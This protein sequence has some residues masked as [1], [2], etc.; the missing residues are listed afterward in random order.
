MSLCPPARR[1]RLGV[2]VTVARPASADRRWGCQYTRRVED[3]YELWLLRSALQPSGRSDRAPRVPTRSL[4]LESMTGEEMD[5]LLRGED[6]GAE[7]DSTEQRPPLD[8]CG[9]SQILNST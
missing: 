4:A 5:G 3:P 8:E 2:W 6:A 9:D 1:W 7:D